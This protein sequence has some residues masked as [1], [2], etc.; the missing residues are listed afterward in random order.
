MVWDLP[1]CCCCCCSEFTML[2]ILLDLRTWTHTTTSSRSSWLSLRC[3]R[4]TGSPSSTH[5]SRSTNLCS[6]HAKKVVWIISFV[7]GCTQE[8][9]LERGWTAIRFWR[10]VSSMVL[11]ICSVWIE[12]GRSCFGLWKF[13]AWHRVTCQPRRSEGGIRVSV[14]NRSPI[15][16]KCDYTNENYSWKEYSSNCTKYCTSQKWDTLSP[17]REVLQLGHL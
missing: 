4:K 11:A 12:S 3:W 9:R 14:P 8:A 1:C 6:G 16:H 5:G 13:G 2:V 10:G 15:Y 7:V 17:L